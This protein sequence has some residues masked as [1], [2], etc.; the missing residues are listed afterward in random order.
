MQEFPMDSYVIDMDPPR[1]PSFTQ[2]MHLL[3]RAWDHNVLARRKGQ[4][5]FNTL[6]LC[7]PKMAEKLRGI[8]GLDPFYDDSYLQ[9]FLAFCQTHWDEP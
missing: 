9:S 6:Y 1:E 4:L 2:F 8:D 7:H 5:A 3:H